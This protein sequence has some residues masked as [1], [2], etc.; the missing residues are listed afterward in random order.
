MEESQAPLI[1]NDEASSWAPR[2]KAR[3]KSA[4][5]GGLTF[6]QRLEQRVGAF[7]DHTL[8]VSTATAWILP[9]LVLAALTVDIPARLFD[10]LATIPS[11][12]P[13]IWISRGD[14]AASLSVFAC[15]VLTRRFGGRVVW[16]ALV[17]SWTI[18]AA[19]A[20]LM[21]LYLAPRL[22]PG[23]LP[24]WRFVIGFS[25][26]WFLAGATAIGSYS[27]L[28]GGRWWR[29]PFVAAL[30]GF[31]VFTLVYFPVVYAGSGVPWLYW[32]FAN[33]VLQAMAAILFLLV[34][35]GLRRRIRPGAGLGGR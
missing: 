33:L 7:A 8:T 23:D 15:I 16:H 4:G 6:R 20:V 17:S 11:L 10:G 21:F 12:K 27:V 13:S 30:L 25:G 22:I 26:G 24:G 9:L 2:N 28:R 3:E 29:A 31:A 14:I 35:A 1:S 18:V 5:G 34:Y 19:L 32:L